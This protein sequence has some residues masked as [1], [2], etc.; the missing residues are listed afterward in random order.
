MNVE[1]MNVYAH[2]VVIE[3]VAPLYI[4]I[5]I[6]YTFIVPSLSLRG[7]VCF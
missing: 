1:G 3:L 6:A 7:I 2:Q 4:I 5:R